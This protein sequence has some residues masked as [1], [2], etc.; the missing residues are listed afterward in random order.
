[1]RRIP[2]SRWGIFGFGQVSWAAEMEGV[3]LGRGFSATTVVGPAYSFS[4]SLSVTGAILASVQ[5]ERD[6][7]LFPVAAV[8][9]RI[10]EQWSLRTL[11]GAI[12]SYLDPENRYQLD[13]SGEYRTRGI[14]L[15]RQAL[16]DGTLARPAVEEREIA[17]GAGAAWRLADSVVVTAFAEY[18]FEREWRF[19][20]DDR[21][22]RTVTAESAPQ[23][24]LR[25]D[26]VF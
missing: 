6:P 13:F 7:R 23:L 19:Y 3:S 22:F 9:W 26:W 25:L 15:R 12:V 11:N 1:L 2:D 5:P 10:N 4:R 24:G 14:R 18:L 8:N 21:S 17:V 16:P 20:H